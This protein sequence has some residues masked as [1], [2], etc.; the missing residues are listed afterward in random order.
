M[1]GSAAHVAANSVPKVSKVYIRLTPTSVFHKDKK[2]KVVSCAC[3]LDCTNCR[4]VCDVG[5]S[6]R[7]EL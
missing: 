6:F 7:N 5:R 2:Y 4:S 3:L 1:L